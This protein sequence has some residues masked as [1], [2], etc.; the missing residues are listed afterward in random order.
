MKEIKWARSSP[1]AVLCMPAAVWWRLQIHEMGTWFSFKFKIW[2][3]KL[4]S[5]CS[6]EVNNKISNSKLFDSDDLYEN[7]QFLL[8]TFTSVHQFASSW[9]TTVSSDIP[10]ITDFL[11]FFDTQILEICRMN[12]K[13]AMK[14]L[15][16]RSDFILLLRINLVQPGWQ[17]KCK[18]LKCLPK[19]A[20]PVLTRIYGPCPSHHHSLANLKGYCNHYMYPH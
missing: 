3:K 7:L 1:E 12:E 8:K 2:L 5:L 13:F 6:K 16:L 14:A 10:F 15:Q 17:L 4:S 9:S 19:S 11:Q 20:S 18:A